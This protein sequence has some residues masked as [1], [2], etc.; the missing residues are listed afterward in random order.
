M[1][2]GF[3][4]S[5][6]GKRSTISA[7]G[8]IPPPPPALAGRRECSH[9]FHFS[10]CKCSAG[11]TLLYKVTNTASETVPPPPSEPI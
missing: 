5:A 2:F 9:P 7:V 11:D 10:S 6:I 1:S 3:F 8:V 4:P